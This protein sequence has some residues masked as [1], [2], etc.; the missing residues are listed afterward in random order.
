MVWRAN[1]R[2]LKNIIKIAV[3]FKFHSKLRQSRMKWYPQLLLR[4]LT[5][6]ET[7]AQN[8]CSTTGSNVS[9]VSEEKAELVDRIQAIVLSRRKTHPFNTIAFG[10]KETYCVCWTGSKRNGRIAGTI[11]DRPADKRLFPSGMVALGGGGWHLAESTMVAYNWNRWPRVLN[12]GRI[13]SHRTAHHNTC[14]LCSCRRPRFAVLLVPTV[15]TL[16]SYHSSLVSASSNC[17]SP[18]RRYPIR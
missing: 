7:V 3:P 15:C 11:P 6:W 8:R 5:C 10:Q 12:I 13:E 4:V 2:N 18:F 1:Y 17:S 9:W 16:S 14:E